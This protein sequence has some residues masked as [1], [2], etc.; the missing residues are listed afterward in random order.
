MYTLYKNMDNYMFMYTYIYIY[1]YIDI[2]YIPLAPVA[3]WRGQDRLLK[4]NGGRGSKDE[5]GTTPRLREQKT[6]VGNKLQRAVGFVTNH[7][8]WFRATS[9]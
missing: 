4:R 7:C 1:I 6:V 8:V 5:C 3:I 2:C 9:H